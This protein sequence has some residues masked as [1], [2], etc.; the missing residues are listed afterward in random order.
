MPG[1]RRKSIYQVRRMRKME[2]QDEIE[3]AGIVVPQG[4]ILKKDL[5]EIYENN[6]KKISEYSSSDSESEIDEKKNKSSSEEQWIPGKDFAELMDVNVELK[7]MSNAAVSGLLDSYKIKHGPVIDSTRQVYMKKLLNSMKESKIQYEPNRQSENG[8]GDAS[9]KIK[10]VSTV[11]QYSCDDEEE[12]E[13]GEI[14]IEEP[15]VFI[16]SEN[17]S[18]K[19]AKTEV[20]IPAPEH[21]IC[22]T[23]TIKDNSVQ[24]SI[25]TISKSVEFCGTTLTRR[26]VITSEKVIKAPVVN[27]EKSTSC[28]IK[29][30]KMVMLLVATSL[31]VLLLMALHIIL[32]KYSVDFY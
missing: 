29:I 22:Y 18:S 32:K 8:S 23:Q 4:K 1:N 2:I 3:K 17:Y 28:L 24:E 7:S 10:Q 20:D 5:I 19:S 11:E 13:E 25:E 26:N 16:Q 9:V 12:K 15:K 31:F 6:M 21:S 27:K 14:V 30:F